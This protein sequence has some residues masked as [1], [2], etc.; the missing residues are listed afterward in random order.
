MATEKLNPAKLP[1]DINNIE[2]ALLG[3]STALPLFTD[4]TGQVNVS[5][6]L[7][8]GKGLTLIRRESGSWIWYYRYRIHNK[9]SRLSLGEY[10]AVTLAQ[11]RQK[12]SEAYTLVK[13][14]IDPAQAR[15]ESKAQA[16]TEAQNTFEQVARLWWDNWRIG[17]GITDK[18]ATSTWRRLEN[19]VLPKL[20]KR[21]IN[22]LTLREIAPVLKA[23]EER[24]PVLADKAW[25]ACGQVFRHACALGI[26]ENNPLA[27]IRRGDLLAGKHQ[28]VNQLRVSI[29]EMPDLLRAI[30]SYDGVVARLGL[31]LMALTF[32]RHGELRGAEWREFDLEGGL[33]TIPAERMK[34]PTPHI[35]PLS[36]QALEIIEQLHRI[37]GHRKHL[38]PSTKG[39]GKVMSDGTLNKAL[40]ILGYKNKM[41]VHGF[42]GVASTELHEMGYPHEHIELQLAHMERNK[43]AAAY[44]HAKYVPQRKKMMQAWADR[45]DELRGTGVVLKMR[46]GGDV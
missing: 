26:M 32:V 14:G 21:S 22:A 46:A 45:L 17:K 12:H 38:F 9:P 34:M 10:P 16:K 36:R 39:E 24:A 31:Q 19:D 30:D 15:Q 43:V 2:R 6:S 23:I 28:V 1:K 25:V 44:N 33:W 13:Q 35:V 4:A 11:A 29:K 18:H 42:R 37:N 5:T 7:S 40:N 41:T 3:D 27:N 20:G 8:D